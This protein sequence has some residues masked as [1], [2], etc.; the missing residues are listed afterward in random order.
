ML[1]RLLSALRRNKAVYSSVQWPFTPKDG[2]KGVSQGAKEGSRG[3]RGGGTSERCDGRGGWGGG[4]C[5][6][7]G[8]AKAKH[9]DF[10]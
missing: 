10:I 1:S 8:G 4:Y 3:G 6:K 9:L 5:G 2:A 7:G